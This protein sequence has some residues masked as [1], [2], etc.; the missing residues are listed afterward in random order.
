MLLQR[1][2][3][4]ISNGHGGNKELKNIVDT[5]GI[6]YVQDNFR[7]SI[8]ENYNSKIDDNVILARESWW[9][10]ILQ[11]RKYGYNDN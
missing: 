7:Y 11:T 5:K 4:Y 9:K 3:N 8:L 1:W 2:Q 6:K 10:E